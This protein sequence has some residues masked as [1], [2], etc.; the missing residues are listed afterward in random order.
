MR[1]GSFSRYYNTSSIIHS[2]NPLCKVLGLLIFVLMVMLCSNIRVIC[3]LSLI[4]FYIMFFSNISFKN[5]FK[6]IW[7]MKVLFI[8]IFLINLVFGVSIYESFI[9]ISRVCL[10][11][12]YS[13]VLLY[14]T[15]TNELAFGFSFLFKPF[16]VFGFPVYKISMAIA[17]SLN[18]VPSLF[19]E[20]NKIIKAQ[21]SR[22]FN[23]S[24]SSFKDKILG[25]KS[26]V[27]PMFVLAFRRADSVSE[28]MELRQFSFSNNRSNIKNFNWYFSDVYMIVCHLLILVFVLIKEVVV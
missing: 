17:L 21:T 27:I 26:V 10:V 14:T 9:M 3:G 24:S 25:I 16:A 19:L 20:S 2:M 12:M 18:F 11:V 13:S 4:L 5:Y 6:S 15:T 28:M 7:S 22:G 8:F 1:S 23:Y